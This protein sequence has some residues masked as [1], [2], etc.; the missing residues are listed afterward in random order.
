MTKHQRYN[1]S[2]KGRARNAR[3]NQRPFRR[4]MQCERNAQRRAFAGYRSFRL[5][6]GW[7]PTVPVEGKPHVREP[8]IFG[9]L[10]PGD[11]RLT[12]AQKIAYRAA[13]QRT[14]ELQKAARAVALD[15]QIEQTIA[16]LETQ[17][18]NSPVR[19]TWTRVHAIRL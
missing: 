5:V 6:F 12:P 15:A 2:E 10:K 8:L 1:A 19:D 3:Y 7:G 9:I 17:F 11:T 16:G 13:S 4:L 14:N 18:P